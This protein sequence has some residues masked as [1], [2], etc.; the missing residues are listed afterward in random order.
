MEMSGQLQALSI[1]PSGKSWDRKLG[2]YF[3]WTGCSGEDKYCATLQEIILYSVEME[4]QKRMTEM[5]EGN[6][7][8]LL[9]MQLSIILDNDQHGTHLLYF[10]IRLL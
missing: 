6:F 8:V 9:I 4:E 1:L 7:Y 10:T 2:G 3:G 5:E